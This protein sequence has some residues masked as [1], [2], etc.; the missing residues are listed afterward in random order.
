MPVKSTDDPEDQFGVTSWD[1]SNV[2]FKRLCNW[3][4]DNSS[5]RRLLKTSRIYTSTSRPSPC[6]NSTQDWSTKLNSDT[7]FKIA[8]KWAKKKNLP[9]LYPW[10]N[11]SKTLLWMYY[12]RL[13]GTNSF[14]KIS[15][16]SMVHLKLWKQALELKPSTTQ[17][18]WLL[19]I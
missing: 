11:L 12:P 13:G 8:I 19:R 10:S 9:S 1:Y 18:K 5:N 4:N 16:K 14:D 7:V 6:F 2:Q 15:W 3:S 17:F